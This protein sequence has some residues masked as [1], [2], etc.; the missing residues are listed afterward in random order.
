[1]DQQAGRLDPLQR[2]RGEPGP[3]RGIEP[4]VGPAR[5]GFVDRPRLARRRGGERVVIA[6]QD[7]G[8]ASCKARIR[9]TTAAGSGP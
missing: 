5:A 1:M 3:L 7:P 6:A 2:Q 9:S 8:T 4:V